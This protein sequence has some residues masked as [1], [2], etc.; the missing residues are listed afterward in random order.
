MK[1]YKTNGIVAIPFHITNL[2][3][4]DFV[5]VQIEKFIIKSRY[6]VR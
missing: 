3:R 5:V 1:N 2:G 4:I 6:P